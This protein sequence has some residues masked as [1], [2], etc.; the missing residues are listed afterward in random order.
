MMR[1]RAN[2]TVHL[3]PRNIDLMVTLDRNVLRAARVLAGLSQAQLA[4][5]A[6][7]GLRTVTSLE[8]GGNVTIEN[9]DKVVGALKRAGIVFVG[10]AGEPPDGIRLPRH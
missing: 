1:A 5:L 6:G 2:E 4:K 3:N 10:E 7:V 9:V 8:K